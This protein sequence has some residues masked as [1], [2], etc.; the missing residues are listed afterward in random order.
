MSFSFAPR[1][2][3]DPSEEV[4]QAEAVDDSENGTFTM[5]TSVPPKRPDLRTALLVSPLVGSLGVDR[6]ASGDLMGGLIKFLFF[7]LLM[8]LALLWNLVDFVFL[9][10]ADRFFVG[11]RIQ[12]AAVPKKDIRAAKI[13]AGIIWAVLFLLSVAT[14]IIV[15][16]SIRCAASES[17]TKGTG[18]GGALMDTNQFEDTQP[19]RGLAESERRLLQATNAPTPRDESPNRKDASDSG[20]NDADTSDDNADTSAEEQESHKEQTQPEKPRIAVDHLMRQKEQELQRQTVVTP[21]W[22]QRTQDLEMEQF[23]LERERQRELAKIALRSG[24]VLA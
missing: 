2:R 24:R 14:S 10:V 11:P 9:L 21:P 13:G 12:W 17:S 23:D 6:L 7:V 18:S 22:Q 15:G 5:S 4:R 3:Q 19:P 1:C 20:Q 8:P 16:S